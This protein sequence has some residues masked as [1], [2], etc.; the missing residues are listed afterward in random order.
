MSAAEI[1]SLVIAVFASTGLWQLVTKI[2]ES[3][4]KKL[5]NSEKISLGVAHERLMF[6]GHTFIKRGYITPDEYE[7]LHDYLYIPYKD[8]GG[9]G[10]AARIMHEIDKLPI[11]KDDGEIQNEK[12]Q[13]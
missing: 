11:Q 2:Y 4:K 6:L 8:M 12:H 10:A 5:T 13:A 1:L 3:K 9:N 7:T